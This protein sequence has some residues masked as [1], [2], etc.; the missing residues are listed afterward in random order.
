MAGE[1]WSDSTLR[2]AEPVLTEAIFAKGPSSQPWIADMV[3]PPLD[4]S[5]AADDPYG[6]NRGQAEGTYTILD[7]EALVDFGGSD[8]RM[9]PGADHPLFDMAGGTT[10]SWKCL[11]YGLA[12]PIARDWALRQTHP[13][14]L[15]VQ[16]GLVVMNTLM[17]QREWLVADTFFRSGNYSETDADSVG[18]GYA[19]PFSD[20]TVDL[21]KFIDA[22]ID[23]V[24]D[25][26]GIKPNVLLTGET[27][28]RLLRTRPELQ[29][30]VGTK[31]AGYTRPEV[32]RRDFRAIE[33]HLSDLFGIMVKIGSSDVNTNGPNQAQSLT[34][35]WGGRSGDNGSLWCGHLANNDMH[36]T[37]PGMGRASLS[38]TAAF[39]PQLRDITFRRYEKGDSG[40]KYVVAGDMYEAV[41]I[42]NST[43]GLRVDELY[44]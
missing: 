19:N 9:A 33:A 26:T 17:A 20:E 13:I 12:V 37:A 29:G 42:V 30:V 28:G 7:A 15:E 14:D 10:G 43:L 8:L 1:I 21:L 31:S 44:A 16:A 11:E 24:K 38:M 41:E 34:A 22:V 3:L 5:S 36:A 23:T 27:E 6:A 18:A 39:R 25:T 4:I 2:P 40:R 35:C 32:Q